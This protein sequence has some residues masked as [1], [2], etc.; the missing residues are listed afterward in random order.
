MIAGDASQRTPIMVVGFDRYNDFFPG[1]VAT[2][3][4]AQG[5]IA[6]DITLELPSLRKQKYITSTVL[7]TLFDDAEFRQELIDTLK[8]RLGKVGRIGFPAV[9]GL[10]NPLEVLN[11]LQ[12]SLG[13]PVFEIPGLPPSIPGIRLHNLLVSAIQQQPGAVN[14]GMAVTNVGTDGKSIHTVWSEA[15]GRQIAHRAKTYV[16]ATGGI[17]GGGITVNNTGYAQEVVFGLPL[18]TPKDRSEWFQADFLA[19][20]GHP[21]F[22][23][24]VRTDPEFYPLD[25]THSR[26]FSNLHVVGNALANCDPIRELSIEGIALA[27]GYKVAEHM[28]R[29]S[30][31]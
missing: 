15:A 24:G 10:H 11:H 13:M 28:G 30:P 6:A 27:S 7:S 22:R 14:S 8:P 20:T 29:K 1:L 25:A 26:I 18:T 16:L 3:L 23:M 2:N 4:N 19:P 5:V 17:L 9:L 21:I 12:T 31:Q